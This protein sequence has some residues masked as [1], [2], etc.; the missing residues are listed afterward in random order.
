M[1]T[2]KATVF[3]DPQSNTID[4][5]TQSGLEQDECPGFEIRVGHGV[6]GISPQRAGSPAAPCVQGWNPWTSDA[7]Q[8]PP[9]RERLEERAFL[10]CGALGIQVE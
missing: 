8:H 7:L 5:G 6:R 4:T 3:T 1:G 2:R 9:T 10:S